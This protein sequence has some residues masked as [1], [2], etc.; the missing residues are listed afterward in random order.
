MGWMRD[1]RARIAGGWLVVQLCLIGALP[2]SL[3]ALTSASAVGAECTCGHGDGAT[4]PMHHPAPQP[5]PQSHPCSCRGTTD[6]GSAILA[7][8]IGP[9]AVLASAASAANPATAAKSLPALTL[10]PLDVSSPPL[11]P[12]PRA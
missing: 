1:R 12:P 10:D 4:C 6:P 7:S 9:T 2:T 3:G 8:L 5:G 11:S